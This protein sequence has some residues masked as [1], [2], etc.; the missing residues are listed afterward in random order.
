MIARAAAVANW[1]R[2]LGDAVSSVGELLDL[3]GLAAADLPPHLRPAD[4]AARDFPLR[5]PRGFVGRMRPGDPA[6]PL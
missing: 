5:V 3:V 1:Q 6:D 2:T 4:G